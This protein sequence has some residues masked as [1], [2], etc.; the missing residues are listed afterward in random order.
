MPA[1]IAGLPV[2]ELLSAAIAGGVLGVVS[3]RALVRDRYEALRRSLA[4]DTRRA[5]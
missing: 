1:H 3:L 5:R 4:G 2:E